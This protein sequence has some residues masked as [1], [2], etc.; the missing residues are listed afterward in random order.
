[1][2]MKQYILTTIVLLVLPLLTV[3]AQTAA[4]TTATAQDTVTVN[5]TD[6]L[7]SFSAMYYDTDISLDRG[8][9]FARLN[10]KRSLKMWS[11]EVLGLG[12]LMAAGTYMVLVSVSTNEDWN[13]WIGTAV[14][15]GGAI[16]VMAP[17]VVWSHHLKRKSDAISVETA[18]LY[19]LGR[20]VEIGTVRF[21]SRA[22]L[23]CNAIGIG[24]RTSF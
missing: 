4:D 3:A 5:K 15:A 21:S 17:F 14:T 7:P 12:A 6:P 13:D 18:Y 19:P 24:V 8:Y 2:H 10:K 20:G 9:D 16:A 22:D 11:V 23:S 1:M